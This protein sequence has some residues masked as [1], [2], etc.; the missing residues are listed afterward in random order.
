LTIVPIKGTYVPIMGTSTNDSPLASALF[1]KVRLGVLGLLFGRPDRAFFVREVVRAVKGGQGAVQRE[2]ARLSEVGL[3]GR[4]E[5]G[6]QVYYNAN[7][8]CPLYAEIRAI[9]TKTVGL[10]DVLRRALEPA[11]DRISVAFVYGSV[12]RGNPESASDVDLL[13]V[14]DVRFG[15]IVELLSPIQGSIGRE[16]NPSVFPSD[17]FHHRVSQDG[18]FLA[19]I[20]SGPKIFVIGDERESGNMAG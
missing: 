1:G 10:V 5:D 9:M 16:I 15:E 14:G 20:V 12:A 18:D 3:L 17:E 19:K 6:R 4:R 2:L 11:Q 8:D 13:V 7:K